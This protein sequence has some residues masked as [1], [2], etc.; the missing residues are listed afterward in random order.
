MGTTFATAIAQQ[1]GECS[2]LLVFVGK[3]EE[4]GTESEKL[5]QWHNA[6]SRALVFLVRKGPCV[7]HI[8]VQLKG[9]LVS[10]GGRVLRGQPTLG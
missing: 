1:Y 5:Q 8:K 2:K 7:V 3:R 10:V 6:D 9:L 4:N